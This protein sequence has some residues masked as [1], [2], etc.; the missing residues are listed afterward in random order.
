MEDNKVWHSSTDD[1][2]CLFS[3]LESE[4]HQSGH[5]SPPFHLSSYIQ[6]Q[7]P[8]F[9]GASALPGRGKLLGCNT[10]RSWQL[11]SLLLRMYRLSL[12]NVM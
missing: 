4:D 6:Q 10:A 9:I 12:Y 8:L 1:L 3:S 7:G 11:N 2:E 5:Q